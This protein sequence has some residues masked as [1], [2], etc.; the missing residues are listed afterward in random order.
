MDDQERTPVEEWNLAMEVVH[1][2]LTDN[3]PT[4]V[5]DDTSTSVEKLEL[6]VEHFTGF[7]TYVP[8]LHG[9]LFILRIQ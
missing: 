1:D 4:S 8:Q 6:Q 5:E 7:S 3:F 2:I 9:F